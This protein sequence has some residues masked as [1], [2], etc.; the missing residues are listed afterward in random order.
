MY[1]KINVYINNNYVYSTKQFRT[2]KE[3]KDDLT[4]R[5]KR[6]EVVMVNSVNL[7]KY[8]LRPTDII[9]CSYK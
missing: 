4:A 1:K 7:I 5:A 6:C 8:Q 2:C 3:C 9:K